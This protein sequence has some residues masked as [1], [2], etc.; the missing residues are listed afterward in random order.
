MDLTRYTRC[1][2]PP[3]TVLDN[4]DA[5]VQK[6]WFICNLIPDEPCYRGDGVGRGAGDWPTVT[7]TVGVAHWLTTSASVPAG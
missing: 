2:P 5:Y 4:G 7:G 3:P 6:E 1:L